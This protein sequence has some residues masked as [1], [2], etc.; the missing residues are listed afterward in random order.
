MRYL[1]LFY[2]EPELTSTV[3]EDEL[4][5]I[6]RNSLALDERLKQSGHYVMSSGLSKPAT[7]K[8]LRVRRSEMRWTDG[9]FVETK[10]YLG[11]FL[12]IEAVDL[13]EAM[14]IAEQDALARIGA[15][16]IRS[17]KGA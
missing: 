3:G 10:E 2:I 1:C 4:A 11:G 13:S 7:A 6:Y 14:R 9:P 8:T 12:I 5:Q 16:E 15:V 17:T